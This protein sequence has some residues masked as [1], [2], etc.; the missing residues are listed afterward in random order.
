VSATLATAAIAVVALAAAASSSAARRR[1]P[2]DAGG[3]RRAVHRPGENMSTRFAPSPSARRRCAR[4]LRRIGAPERLADLDDR[5]LADIGVSR[6]EIDSIEAE[7]R[8]RSADAPAHRR[9][10]APCVTPSR[11]SRWRSCSAL[12]AA[13]RAATRRRGRR[14]RRRA[15]G[16]RAEHERAAGG[17]LDRALVDDV[18]RSRARSA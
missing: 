10:A 4:T 2:V 3:S 13:H 8:G 11:A 16:A 6:S 18:R 9:G 15:A 17:A 1:G 14:E 12:A 7:S 5:T